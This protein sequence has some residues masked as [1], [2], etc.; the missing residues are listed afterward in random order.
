M[1]TKTSIAIFCLLTLV[2]SARSQGF[3]YDQQSSTETIFGGTSFYLTNQIVGQSFKPSLNAIDFI[4]LQF[5]DA[6]PTVVLGATVFVNLWSGSISNST[7]LSSTTPVFMP[8]DFG[9]GGASNR[10][11]TNFFFANSVTLTPGA[12]YFLQPILQSGDQQWTVLSAFYFGYAGGSVIYG[13]VNQPTFDLWF[14][15]G[16]IAVPE[17][18]AI[19]LALLG[20]G[21]WLL[22]R[23]QRRQ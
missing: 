22:V 8:N 1:K 4:S 19:C 11:F 6:N 23:R 3:I 13:G 17:P 15:E 5:Y 7:L 20:S 16:V 12:T 10:G 2:I 21:A 9:R 18:A 14:R